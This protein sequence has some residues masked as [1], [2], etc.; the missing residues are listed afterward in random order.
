MAEVCIAPGELILIDRFGEEKVNQWRKE[1][2][3][4]Q[5]NIIVVE[6]KVA[7]LRPV[8]SQEVANFSMMVAEPDKGLDVA[9]KYLLEELWIDGDT[10]L[11]DDEEYFISAMLQMQRIIDLKKSFFYRV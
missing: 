1:Y 4:R 2:A 5:L 8:G 10:V 9:S 3:P 6:D 7:V 11:R